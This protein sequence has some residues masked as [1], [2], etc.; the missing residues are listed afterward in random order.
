[1]INLWF[2]YAIFMLLLMIVKLTLAILIFVKLDDVVAEVPKWLKEAFQKD[3]V[4]FQAIE[5]TV[6]KNT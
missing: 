6:S 2:Q 1:M 3:R 4:A 5:T